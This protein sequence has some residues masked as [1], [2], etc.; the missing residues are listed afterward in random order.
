MMRGALDRCCCAGDSNYPQGSKALP[1][2][3]TADAFVL[4][5]VG[6]GEAWPVSVMEAT[7]A[8]LSAQLLC[9]DFFKGIIPTVLESD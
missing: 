5:S 4:P 6:L 7:G 2:L 9:G 3:S 8:A 1:T